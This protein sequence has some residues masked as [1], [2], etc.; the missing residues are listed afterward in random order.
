MSGSSLVAASA[1]S[2]V[3]LTTTAQAQQQAA[4]AAAGR[5][6]N[7]VV[8]MGD[9]VG[10]FN[11]GAYHRGIMSGKTPNLDKLASEGMMFT[12]YYAEA[13][14]TAGR[15]NFITGE[16]PIRTG[17]TTVGQAGA[18][19]GIPAQAATL[20]TALKAQ[21]YATG[22]FGKNH[23]GD[24]N[25]YLPTL[26]GFDEFFGY[27]YHLDAMS[28]PYWYSFPIDEKYY[29]TYGPRSVIHSYATDTEDS[30]EMPRWGKIGKQRIVD[31]GPLPPFPDMSNVPNMHDLPFL[32]P[33]YDMTTFDEVLVKASTDFM[34]RAKRDGKPFFV[35]HN[36]TRMHVWTFLS[37][38]YSSMQN[39]Q[40]NY[41]LEEAGM[42][43]M[44][45]SIGALM[46]HLDDI[47]EANNT[48]L[49]FT[50]DNGAEVFTWPDGGMTPFKNT[51]GTVGEGGFRVPCIIRW[52]GQ[53]KPGTVENGI[54][55]GLDWFPTLM[56]A[57]GNPDI[58]TQLLRGVK[59]GERTYKNH[60]DGYNQMDLLTG[61]GP[62]KR[63]EIFYFGGP[64][65]GAVRL[66]DMKFTF[67]VQPWGWPGEKVTTDMPLLTNLRQ[68]PFERLS[69]MRGESLNTGSP[70]Y[71]NEFFARE[72]WRFVLVQ[73][74]VE[75]LA[76]TAVDYP[77]MQD[78]ASFNLD[79]VKKKIDEMIKHR[80]GQ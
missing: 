69:I 25:K 79:A 38:K 27:L 6:P 20:A 16:L 72:F 42:T 22:Q 56:A 65:L 21:G 8:I 57:A 48:I 32:K 14:C 54:F 71:M 31:E 37:K 49:I 19:V 76:L 15:A 24:L 44:D 11:I 61:K 5:R 55:S 1:L 78:P 4:P 77:P 33:K 28:D 58:T 75:K 10:W 2:A 36:T 68:D 13:S 41:G 30:T 59:L 3:G 67:F 46:K 70:G 45:D 60:L 9:D 74:Y 23:L 51:K 63:Q 66:D 7:I 64:H 40:T 47:G 52:P 39:S 12:D 53:I 50:T 26:H 80:E 17:L 34:S 18:D 73:Q 29:N 35:W 43:Q 62:S